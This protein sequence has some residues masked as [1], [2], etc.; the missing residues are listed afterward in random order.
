[1]AHEGTRPKGWLGPWI[2]Q[3]H[4]TPD[5][6]HEAGYEYLLD[7]CM[8]D[9]P[10]WLRTRSGRILAVPYPQEINDIPA[11]VT[12]KVGADEFAEMIIDNF[13]EMLRQSAKQPLVYGVALHAFIAGQP[14]RIVHL[15]R[16]L[17]HLCRARDRVWFAS[18]GEIAAHFAAHAPIKPEKA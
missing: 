17:E 14:F 12:R 7:W 4:L 18:T 2:S 11:V 8:D 6:L 1:M 3:S 5:L 10:V 15:R 16:A 9:Q 13:D